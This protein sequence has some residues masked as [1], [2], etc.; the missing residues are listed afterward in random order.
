MKICELLEDICIPSRAMQEAIFVGYE[1]VRKETRRVWCKLL[2]LLVRNIL[3]IH[4]STFAKNIYIYIYIY[5]QYFSLRAARLV[6]T[7]F[8]VYFEVIYF[9]DNIYSDEYNNVTF[10]WV[11][12]PFLLSTNHNICVM[13]YKKLNL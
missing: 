6:I 10:T 2:L 7:S 4:N 12:T 13:N 3:L 8:T 1:D 11:L 9:W 5:I